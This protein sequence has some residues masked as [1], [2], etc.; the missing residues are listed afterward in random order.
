MFSEKGGAMK[1]STATITGIYL[2]AFSLL[3]G[4]HCGAQTR[5]NHPNTPK[6]TGVKTKTPATVK[7]K[8]V[9]TTKSTTG[10]ST[11]GKSTAGSATRQPTAKTQAGKAKFSNGLPKSTADRPVTAVKG[12][13]RPTPTVSAS[14]D[15]YTKA[16]GIRAGETSGITYK[17]FFTD[18]EAFEAILGV[19]PNAMGIT[20]LYEKYVPFGNVEGL[21][22]YFGGGAHLSIGTGKIYYFEREGSRYY[23]YRRD[24]PGLAVG[25]DGLVGAEYKIPK[26]PF[27]ISFDIKPFIEVN[28]GGVLYTSF[29][30]G[31]G[32]K[33]AF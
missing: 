6:A 11:A 20:G 25:I 3:F 32:I 28:N 2:C 8:T 26:A 19:W 22:W 24:Y 18:V 15:L 13:A 9:T 27:A 29:D 16:I 17:Q 12:A 14:S 1:K 10:K 30:P 33:V 4:M 23:A 5:T 7:T 21:N 31:L